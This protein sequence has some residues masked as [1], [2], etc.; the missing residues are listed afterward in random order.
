MLKRL[1]A[2][3]VATV[4]ITCTTLLAL[5][6][7]SALDMSTSEGQLEAYVKMRGDLSGKE[8]IA[9]WSVTVYA[10]VPGEKPQAIF[11]TDGYNVG[12]AE[13]QADGGYLWI[14]REVSYYKDVKTRE[15]LETWTNPFTNEV[16]KVVQIANDPVNGKFGS[17]KTTKHN[18]PWRTQGDSTS[19]LMN[20]PLAYPNP[21]QPG[22]FPKESSGPVYLASEHFGFVVKTADLMNDSLSSVPENHNWFRTGPWLPWMNMG[23]KPG[24]LLYSGVGSKLGSWDQLPADVKAYTMKHFPQYRH[25][26]SSYTTPNETSW[27]YYKKLKQ[28]EAAK[29]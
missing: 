18:F 20:V 23:G 14:S 9:D 3:E 12:R 8:V 24:Y 26:P 28:A 19:M 11:L 4:A 15:I 2:K 16:V 1:S 13:K 5:P 27:T 6:L 29:K 25:A 10:V 21:L 17:P 22:E 7:A